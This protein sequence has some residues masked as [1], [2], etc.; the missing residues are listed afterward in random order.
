MIKAKRL[1]K[2]DKIAIVSLSRGLL[3]EAS[4]KHYVDSGLKRLKEFGLEPVIM[5]N[6]LKGIDYLANHPEE[7]AE[8]L[9][10]A[11]RDDDIKGIMCAIGGDDTYRTLPYLMENEEFKQLVQTKPK[12]FTGYSDS[13]VNHLM[14]YKLGLTTYYGMAFITDI[15]EMSPEMLPYTK[16]YFSYYLV[17]SP[18]YEKIKPS[19]IWYEERLDYSVKELGKNRIS[20]Q[21]EKGF[22]LLQGDPVFEGE[23]LGGCVDSLHD[24]LKPKGHVDQPEMIAK[25]DIFPSAEDWQGKVVFFE[26]SELRETPEEL[27]KML[28]VLKKAGMFDKINGVIIGKPQDEVYYTEYI[29]PIL[30]VIDNPDLP[31]VYNVNFGHAT[32]MCVLPYGIKVKVDAEKQEIVFIENPFSN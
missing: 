14:F 17:S 20:H 16:E 9:L 24:M 23:L 12:P 7:R 15:G 26:T 8:D 13:T 28:H 19:P 11:F 32:P 30:A 31:V 18:T 27:E 4:T 25:Y 21:D 22:V 10:T 6:A 5:P 29:K 1:K 3:G 2:G